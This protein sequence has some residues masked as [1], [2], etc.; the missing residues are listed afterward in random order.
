MAG[1][2]GD[3]QERRESMSYPDA[4]IEKWGSWFD[5]WDCASWLTL[6]S[7]SGSMAIALGCAAIVAWK[8]LPL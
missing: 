4:I 7:I 6:I 8:T 3:Q 1:D 2:K 5:K